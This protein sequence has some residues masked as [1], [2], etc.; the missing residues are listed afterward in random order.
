MGRLHAA[1]VRLEVF[2]I[3]DLLHR[4]L[5]CG[6]THPLKATH[7]I[8]PPVQGRLDSVARREALFEGCTPRRSW[9]VEVKRPFAFP[10]LSVGYSQG[11]SFLV[12]DVSVTLCV[13]SF[14]VSQ[15]LSVRY[16]QGF[17][18]LSKDLFFFIGVL[19]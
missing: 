14:H 10:S 17:S 4:P 13:N 5:K 6:F 1:R 9:V 12:E 7:F 2:E 19:P 15:A 18:S 11:F 16:S 3:H 8:E